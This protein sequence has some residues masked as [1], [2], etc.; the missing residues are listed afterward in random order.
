MDKSGHIAIYPALIQLM[1]N[2]QGVYI[3]FHTP[4]LQH[5]YMLIYT[6]TYELTFCDNSFTRKSSR[7]YPTM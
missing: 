3:Y 4:P 2:A 1:L 7:L 6:H 5:S